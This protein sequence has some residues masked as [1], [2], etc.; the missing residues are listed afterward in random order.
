MTT[1][2]S[3]ELTADVLVVGAGPCGITLANLLGRYGV[4]TLAVDADT[5][6]YPFPRAVGIDD[7]SLRTYQTIGVVDRLLEDIVQNTPIRYHT[8]WGRMIAHVEPSIRPFGWPR[9][10]LFLQPLFEAALREHLA[11]RPSVTLRLGHRLL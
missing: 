3:T 5:Q 8:S 10:N 2:G 1:T 11:G 6:V 9:R 4:S 7:E